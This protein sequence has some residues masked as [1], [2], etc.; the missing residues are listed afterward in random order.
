[1]NIKTGII[2]I[3]RAKLTYIVAICKAWSKKTRAYKRE[4]QSLIGS[5]LYIHKCVRPTRLFVNRILANLREAPENGTFSLSQ[6]F[7]RDVSWF[8]AFLP[9]FNGR[10]CF[11]NHSK[12]LVNDLF[13]D[14]SLSGVG[15]IWE[16]SV[17]AIPLDFIQGLPLHC[18][19]VHL[20]MINVFIALNL[21]KH[22]LQGRTIVIHCDNMAVVNSISSGC[23]W[24][25][26]LGSVARNIWLLTATHDIELTVL[27]IPG[28][29]NI[30]AD[31]LSRWYG[32]GISKK[33]ASKLLHLSWCQVNQEICILNQT[34]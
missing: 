34:I 23:S 30:Y 21:W 33:M 6:D 20:E 31:T 14:A 22:K 10:V 3:P 13:V 28:K 27:H 4:L 25:S 12:P 26:F 32:G 11:D 16:G 18:T 7:H 15:G 8:N 17:Y 2:Y 1:M 5:L 24:D 19:I 29:K 9:D